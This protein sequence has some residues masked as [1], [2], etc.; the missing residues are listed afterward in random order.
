MEGPGPVTR[1][2]RLEEEHNEG[3]GA[4]RERDAAMKAGRAAGGPRQDGGRFDGEEDEEDE[5]LEE[6]STVWV[7]QGAAG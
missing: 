5:D 1:M 4:G 6:E 3:N 2:S 7:S